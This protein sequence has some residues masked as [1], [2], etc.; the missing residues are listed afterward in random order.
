MSLSAEQRQRFSRQL[1]LKEIGAQGQAALQDAHILVVGAGGLG[2]P[3]LTYLASAG[4][5]QITLIDPDHVSLSNLAR[6]FLFKEEDIGHNKAEAAAAHLQ[7]KFPDCR[8]EPIAATLECEN[9]EAL[10]QAVDLVIEGVDRFA[11]RFV[12][13]QLS[14]KTKTPF[15]SS[16]VGRFDGQIAAFAPWRHGQAACYQC[17]VPQIPDNEAACD[18]L[19]V[20]GACCGIIGT[21]TALE[22][23]KII[24]KTPPLLFDHMLIIDSLA[25]EMRRIGLSRDPA[26]PAHQG[27]A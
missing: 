24:T 22:A 20:L 4:V 2:N 23:I 21:Q 13:N 12:I 1:L 10:F 18:V 17:L 15:L 16:A 9:G 26:C 11:P 14:L 5:G 3:L 27:A 7:E 6:Q 8:I 19:G 25:G